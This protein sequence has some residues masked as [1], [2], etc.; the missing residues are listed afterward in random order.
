[1]TKNIITFA[2]DKFFSVSQYSFAKEMWDILE[3]TREGTSDVKRAR[4]HIF[5]QEYELCK[6]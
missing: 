3:V 6:M 2:C 5:I 1:M 4:K